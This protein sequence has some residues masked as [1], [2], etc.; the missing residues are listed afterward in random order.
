MPEAQAELA[1][2]MGQAVLGM[3]AVSTTTG[4]V[5]RFTQICAS[6]RKFYFCERAREHVG[7]EGLYTAFLGAGF[8]PLG[9]AVQEQWQRSQCRTAELL[10]AEFLGR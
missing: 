8:L 7:V 5:H 3:V 2:M 4:A 1:W 10:N 9:P 6:D